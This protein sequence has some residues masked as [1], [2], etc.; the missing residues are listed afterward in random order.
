[1]INAVKRIKKDG[2]VS[3]SFYIKN[4]VIHYFIGDIPEYIKD[5]NDFKA[6]NKADDFYNELQFWR[7]LGYS[8]RNYAAPKDTRKGNRKKYASD[9]YAL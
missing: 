9:I 3:Q 7:D 8:L 1:M 4:G 2:E 6:V 5:I